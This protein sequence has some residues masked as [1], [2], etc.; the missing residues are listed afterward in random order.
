MDDTM[1]YR[2]M[3]IQCWKTAR[4]HSSCYCQI[5]LDCPYS[6]CCQRN[7]QRSG[8]ANIPSDIMDRMQEIFE[9]PKTTTKYPWDSLTIPIH[10]EDPI[11]T[12]MIWCDIIANYWGT[13]APPMEIESE[14]DPTIRQ[15]TTETVTHQVDIQSRKIISEY[16]ARLPTT[17]LKS[18]MA[19]AMNQQRQAILDT[20]RKSCHQGDPVSIHDM[21]ET[22]KRKCESVT[23]Q[24]G[25]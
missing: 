25:L 4:L 11:E 2:S 23:C 7:K 17:R 20:C 15:L 22:F 5:Y 9:A 8:T 14:L 13:P 19:K 6:V 10:S 16:V 24:Y 1:H 3:R 18:T 12:S 21:L